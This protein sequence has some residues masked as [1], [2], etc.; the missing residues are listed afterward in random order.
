MKWHPASR[1]GSTSDM[2]G[3]LKDGKR[4]RYAI[5]RYAPLGICP[6]DPT[7]PKYIPP[8]HYY[9]HTPDRN[10]DVTKQVL[11]YGYPKNPEELSAEIEKKWKRTAKQRRKKAAERLAK[12]AVWQKEIF[13]K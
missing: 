3:I 5:I 9:I 7:S 10:Y 12:D 6:K 1:P 8:K 13:K 4:Y 2:L 11:Y